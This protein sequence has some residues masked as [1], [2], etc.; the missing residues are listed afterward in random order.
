M[1]YLATFLMIFALCAFVGCANDVV[2]DV[3]GDSVC[4]DGCMCADGHC[5]CGGVCKDVCDCEGCNCKN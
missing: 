3:T 5:C 4:V 2:S 1:R